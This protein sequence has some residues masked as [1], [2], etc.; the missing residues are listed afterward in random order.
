MK[1]GTPGF[2]GARL[3]EAREARGLSGASLADMLG[4]SRQAIALYENDE[5]SPSPE[6]VGRMSTALN[7]PQPFFL[8][9]VVEDHATTIFFRS[10]VSAT[11]NARKKA[12]TRRKWLDE[13]TQYIAQSIELPSVNFPPCDFPADPTKISN[14]DIERVATNVRRFWRLGDGPI[15]D[16]TL[17][18]ENNGAII[19]REPFDDEKVDAH[20]GWAADI[21][22]IILS[23]D[24]HSAVRSRFD[25]AHEL[26]HLVL[27]RNVDDARLENRKA[28]LKLTEN[29]ADRFAGAF[30]LPHAT[31]ANDLSLPTLEALV[32]LKPKWKVSVASMIMRA[33]H[34]GLISLERVDRLWISY[35]R[36]KWHGNEPYDDQLP[37]ERPRL[38]SLAFDLALGERVIARDETLDDLAFAPS[39]IE[40]LVGLPRGA[41]SD[42]LPPVRVLPLF[43]GRRDSGERPANTKPGDVVPFPNR[44]RSEREM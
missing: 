29:Q 2:V 6:M 42:D 14:D 27:H 30:L 22:F 28:D 15:S 16:V 26:G 20:S 44:V 4:V 37:V 43:A 12:R 35:G 25:V 36:R 10:R 32:A 34:L 33:K 18:V 9:P 24:K 39:D 1:L 41:F 23:A 17:L 38:L 31:F 5:R 13:I 21:P 19:A 8:R 7:L 3:R 40:S 11:K